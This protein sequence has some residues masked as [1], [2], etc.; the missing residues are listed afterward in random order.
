MKEDSLELMDE[1]QEEK[2][3]FETIRR[4]FIRKVYGIILFQLIITTIVVYYAMTNEFI[5]KYMYANV[6]PLYTSCV[7]S[8]ILVIILICGQITQVIPINYFI[9]IFITL[10]EAVMVSYTTIYFEPISVL[11][12]AGLTMI[13]V[14]GLTMYACF[15]KRDITMMGGFLFCCSLLL[16]F[17]GFIG[18]FFRSHF[19]QMFLNSIGVL[20]MSLYLIYDTQLVIGN[21]RHLIDIDDY[22]Y[23]ALLIYLD[24]ISL[25]IRILRL[26]G[27]KKK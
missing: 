25:F 23:G 21:K 16:I 11:A 12:C 9:L 19:Y 7:A 4:G 3:T 15:T 8:I 5:M 2:V 27:S 1:K 14:F 24:I 13:I 18:I 10:L 17:L 26:L 6:W 20:L 22:I